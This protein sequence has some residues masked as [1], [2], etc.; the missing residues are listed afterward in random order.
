MDA[1]AR[2]IVDAISKVIADAIADE[3]VEVPGIEPGCF[4][5]KVGLLRA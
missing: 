5:A 4:S 2:V 3:I 1:I